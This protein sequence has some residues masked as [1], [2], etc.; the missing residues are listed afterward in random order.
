MSKKTKRFKHGFLLG[1]GIYAA[2][3]LILIVVGLGFFWKFIAAFE[4]S[5]PLNTMDAY[6]AKL[7]AEHIC[8]TQADLIAEVDHY[9]QSEDACRQL[10]IDAVSGDI[11]YAKKTSESTDTQTVYV[12]RCGSRII[13]S[14]TMTTT[15]IDQYGF[16]RWKISSESFDLSY[17]KGTKT[18]T[19]TVPEEFPVYVNGAQLN[20][21]YITQ[22]DIHYDV[23][24]EFYD[25]YDLPTMVTY[26]V[27]PGL[28]DYE[29]KVTDPDG[30]PVVIDETTDYDQFL[31]NCSDTE[32]TEAKA[33]VDEFIDSYVTFTGSANGT[34]HR[35]YS[36]LMKFVVKDSDFASRLKMALDGLTYAQSKGDEIV[37][38]TMNQQI[39]ITDDKYLCDVTYVVDTTGKEGVVQT[40]N[41]AQIIVVRT[42]DGFLVEKLTSY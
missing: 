30:N 39:A 21:D 5:R 40:T 41:N 16:A 19:V 17:L 28:G 7:N 25:D 9:I 4:D 14:V 6:M 13:G 27:A 12:L 31:N 10:V 29:M 24:E 22:S 26:T 11:T 3:F 1:L 15:E 38:I 37:S 2:L 34:E 35:N 32:L 18:Y 20:A 23:L 42:E 36:N 33:F 8:D